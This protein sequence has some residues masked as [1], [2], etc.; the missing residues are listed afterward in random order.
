MAEEAM[1]APA[2]TRDTPADAPPGEG[3]A[4]ETV[5]FEKRYNDLRPDYDRKSQRLAE[6]EELE[7]SLS[8]PE[9]Q[10]EA[11]RRFEIELADDELPDDDDDFGD[12]PEFRDPRVDK[13][14]EELQAER[15]QRETERAQQQ[16]DE[17][18]TDQIE[19]IE[20]TEGR[21]L[22]EDEIAILHDRALLR[23]VRGEQPSVE[24][25]YQDLDKVWDK[26]SKTY[27]ESKKAP[28]VT[29]GRSASEQPDLDDEAARHRWLQQRL[30]AN[31][32]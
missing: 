14:M 22:D 29:A 9:R 23:A 19:A 8:D 13:L 26:R 21:E 16:F 1:E 30:E 15:Q 25:L 31:Q 6:L 7:R 28:R 20:K 11:L 10:A 12:D 2:E 24:A 18:F 5:D 32:Q 4:H 27:V 17:S 3:H